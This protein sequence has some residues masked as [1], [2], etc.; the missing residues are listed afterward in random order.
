MHWVTQSEYAILLRQQCKDLKAH[1]FRHGLCLD[2]KRSPQRCQKVCP[3]MKLGH[4]V[5]GKKPSLGAGSS[6]RVKRPTTTKKKKKKSP[7]INCGEHVSVPVYGGGDVYRPAWPRNFRFDSCSFCP[8]SPP[9]SN[10]TPAPHS[11]IFP[12]LGP[13]TSARSKLMRHVY[14]YNS[15]KRSLP[16]RH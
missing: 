13:R 12:A 16:S 14:N 1:A 11:N 7:A 6:G 10:P 2:N 4:L 8:L 3:I 15:A 9:P 5:L